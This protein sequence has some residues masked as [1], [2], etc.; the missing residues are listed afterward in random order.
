MNMRILIEID[1][2]TAAGMNGTP[3]LLNPAQAPTSLL[4]LPPPAPTPLLI[5]PISDMER[6]I[7]ELDSVR[8]AARE[9]CH[10]VLVNEHHVP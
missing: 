9:K 8:F 2:G 4:H 7:L 6:T 1:Q 10:G 3:L 5:N